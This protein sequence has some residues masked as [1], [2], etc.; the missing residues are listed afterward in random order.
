MSRSWCTP[1]WP[2]RRPTLEPRR[3]TSTPRRGRAFIRITLPLMAPA[4]IA[5]WL[6]AFTL[7]LDDV[8]VASFNLGLPA[9]RPCRWSVFSSINAPALPRRLSALA[10]LSVEQGGYGGPARRG[11]GG[12]SA[13]QQQQCPSAAAPIGSRARSPG[14]QPCTHCKRNASTASKQPS[15]TIAIATKARHMIAVRQERHQPV[16]GGA[17]LRHAA[18]RQGRGDPRHRGQRDALHR[19]QRHRRATQGGGRKSSTSTAV[20]PEQAG[21]DHHLHRRQGGDLQHRHLLATL[22]AG[23]DEVVIPSPAGSAIP[24]SSRWPMAS[25]C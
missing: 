15:L 6:L 10:T 17:G 20:L 23:G 7:S 13:A 9:P 18:Q 16:A 19:T 24:T 8:V 4:L 5:G 2:T 21:G 22:D 11:L 12:C 3:W 14:T 25:R 1:G